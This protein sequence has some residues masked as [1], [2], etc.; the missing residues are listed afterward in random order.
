MGV[1]GSILTSH[2]L[3]MGKKRKKELHPGLRACPSYRTLW[4]GRRGKKRKLYIPS[5]GGEILKTLTNL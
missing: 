1:K 4:I 2:D 5:D 3:D